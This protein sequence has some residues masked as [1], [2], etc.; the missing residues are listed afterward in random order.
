MGAPV[1]RKNVLCG[2]GPRVFTDAAV[3][4]GQWTFE[5]REFL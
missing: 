4:H 2:E 5:P 1:V 3:L